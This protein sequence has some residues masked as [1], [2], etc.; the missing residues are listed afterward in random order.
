[1]P[2]TRDYYE[3]LGVPRNADPEAIRGAYRALAKRYHPDVNKEAGAEE[4]FKEV[5][6]AYGVLSDEQRRAAYDQYGHDGLNRTAFGTGT[7]LEDLGDLFD[8]FFRGFGMGGGHSRRSPRKGADLQTV[9]SLTFEESISGVEKEVEV[10]R[11]EVCSVCRGSRA[12]PGTTP[13]RCPVCQ[14]TGEERRMR[15]TFLGSMVNVTVCSKCGGLGEIVSSP[16]KN[17]R[18]K[19]VE[20][21]TRKLKVPIPP[22]VDER[23]ANPPLGRRRAGDVRRTGGEP[24]HPC[25]GRSRTN[26][27]CA[28]T[29]TYG[30][31]S[32]VNFSQ[33][34]MG[35]DVSVETASGET[36]LHIP[37]GTQPGQVFRLR[38]KGVPHLQQGGRGDLFVVVNI[39]VPGHAD[40]GAEEDFSRSSGSAPD[41][42]PKPQKHT[43]LGCPEGYSS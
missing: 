11:M 42:P 26:S 3:I 43:L 36:T 35:A 38:G 10:S 6:E 41:S 29:A 32:D 4:R 14:G 23:H 34:A 15:Q 21:K 37:A 5:N 19:G 40:R 2:T 16:C 25:A 30:C 1:M 12:E 13:V 17:C 31:S 22:G 9:V 20:R 7:G 28:G 33:A 8:E 27:S 18:G 39:V 24:I